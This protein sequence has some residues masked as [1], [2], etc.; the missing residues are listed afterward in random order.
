[1]F[2]AALPALEWSSRQ[3]LETGEVTMENFAS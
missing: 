3:E 1:M 2:Q